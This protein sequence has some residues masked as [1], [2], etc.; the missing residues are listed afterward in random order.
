MQFFITPQIFLHHS[1]DGKLYNIS[2]LDHC[3]CK[4]AD[5]M[6]FKICL[7]WTQNPSELGFTLCCETKNL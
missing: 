4:I 7:T 2:L 5:S 3:I 1:I 6:A